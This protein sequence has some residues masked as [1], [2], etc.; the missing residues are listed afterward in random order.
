MHKDAK[1]W[2]QGKSLVGLADPRETTNDPETLVLIGG[3]QRLRPPWH[4]IR[5]FGL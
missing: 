4:G 2:L 3:H 1:V 5:S